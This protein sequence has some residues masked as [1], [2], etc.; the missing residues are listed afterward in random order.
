MLK[1]LRKKKGITQK[2]L[3]AMLGVRQSTIS[4]IERGQNLPSVALAKNLS[5]ILDCDWTVF[6]ND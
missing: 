2:E 1:S 6:F 3:S 4:M 5:K